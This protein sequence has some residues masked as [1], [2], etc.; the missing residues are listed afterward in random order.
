MADDAWN[1]YD[2]YKLQDSG[3]NLGSNPGQFKILAHL[4]LAHLRKRDGL[5]EHRLLSDSNYILIS[6]LWPL[7]PDFGKLQLTI[8]CNWSS[9][10]LEESKVYSDNTYVAMVTKINHK[11]SVYKLDSNPCLA[12]TPGGLKPTNLILEQ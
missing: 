1:C 11:S 6:K 8:C 9:L 10:L 2:M 12:T 4:P 5:L 3:M 7:V